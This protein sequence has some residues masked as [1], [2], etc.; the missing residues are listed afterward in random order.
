M[1][2]L[3]KRPIMDET[4]YLVDIARQHFFMLPWERDQRMTKD[5]NTKILYSID[6]NIVVLKTNPEFALDE[7]NT[8]MSVFHKDKKATCLA[9]CELLTNYIFNELLKNQKIL[10]TFPQIAVEIKRMYHTVWRKSQDVV[11]AVQTD[12]KSFSN[13]IND[14]I[15]EDSPEVFIESLFANHK[16]IANLIF[17]TTKTPVNELKRFSSL[18]SK[19]IL[20][21]PD[22]L[23]D[24]KDENDNY[25]LKPFV[26]AY[27]QISPI[28]LEKRKDEVFEELLASKSNLEITTTSDKINKWAEVIACLDLVNRELQKNSENAY[29]VFIT[30]STN[31]LR[32]AIEIEVPGKKEN[33][34][35]LYLRHPRAFLAEPNLLLENTIDNDARFD[36][37]DYT[38]TFIRS[39]NTLIKII[40]QS[41]NPKKSKLLN[42]T[43]NSIQAADSSLLSS[44]KGKWENI[45]KY[46][47]VQKWI[48]NKNQD[49][50][51]A[52]RN[53]FKKLDRES[54]EIELAERATS[55]ETDFFRISLEIG[56]CIIMS[57]YT[58]KENRS[59]PVLWFENFPKTQSFVDEILKEGREKSRIS[60]TEKRKFKELKAEDESGYSSML[61]LSLLFFSVGKWEKSRRL[62]KR[63]LNVPS[64]NKDVFGN[65]AS[66]L[67]TISKRLTLK[68]KSDL[69]ALLPQLDDAEAR[70]ETY[71]KIRK[72]DS[73][74]EIRFDNERCAIWITWHLFDRFSVDNF[75]ITE[76]DL[77]RIPT[78]RDIQFS[79]YRL[80]N[81]CKRERRP[82]VKAYIQRQLYTNYFSVLLMRYYGD[83]DKLESRTKY[84][85]KALKGFAECYSDIEVGKCFA[86]KLSFRIWVIY[87]ISIFTF[88]KYVFG[89]EKLAIESEKKL[90]GYLTER[91]IIS[92]SLLP[93]DR[94]RYSFY[95]AVV[96]D[97]PPNVY[98][99][100]NPLV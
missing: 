97:N 20:T 72:I 32:M 64:H 23:V 53:I 44:I 61:V 94:Q 27:E 100:A 98:S 36:W 92:R 67:L 24:K 4:Q 62:S 56:S 88:G 37:F 11:N 86:G 82:T 74:G 40:Q 75:E 57:S 28:R 18:L 73:D 55:I 58:A 39:K 22:Y 2:S 60:K 70:M 29:M 3:N 77:S 90:K 96:Q 85:A 80:Q 71:K 19:K 9:I 93:Y 59:T 51:I 76:E 81:A 33:F 13:F 45:T 91:R 42:Q 63:A 17:D 6:T 26:K 5:H 25:Y 35:E 41:F 12:S 54:V 79:L 52:F 69:Q 8:S 87:N 43:V 49:Y 10:I 16:E 14:H 38:S 83:N 48:S 65:E 95:K 78:L 1:Q 30:C 50:Y 68:N 47:N 66:Y 89:N 84:V 21:T 15:H 31:L 7:G 34:A 46:L 99:V